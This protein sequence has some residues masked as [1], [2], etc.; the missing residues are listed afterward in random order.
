M[1]AGHIFMGNIHTDPINSVHEEAS[2]LDPT[3]YFPQ[4]DRAKVLLVLMTEGR[5]QNESNMDVPEARITVP[6]TVADENGENQNCHR[7]CELNG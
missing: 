4:R 3:A 6:K 5:H 1:V 2:S 7:F